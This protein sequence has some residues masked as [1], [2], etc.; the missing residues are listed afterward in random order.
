MNIRN[1]PTAHLNLLSFKTPKMTLML[2][3]HNAY[4]AMRH[5]ELSVS[6]VLLCSACYLLH[7][8]FLHG[9]FL[10]PEDGVDFSSETSADFQQSTQLYIPECRRTHNHR[11]ES[12]KSHIG[13]KSSLNFYPFCSFYLMLYN[14]TT[15]KH[16]LNSLYN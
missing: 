16:I 3:A 1:F 8:G 13:V 11:C 14:N 15:L 7:A 12:L 2:V 6:R 10:D 5:H 9:L 4:S